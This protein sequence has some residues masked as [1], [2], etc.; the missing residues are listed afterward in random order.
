MGEV[1]SKGIEFRASASANI[2][3][4]T[5]LHVEES[6]TWLD[7][8]NITPGDSNYGKEL[9]YSS[10]TRSLFI[11]E[12]DR[13][14]WGSLTVLARYRGHEYSDPANTPSGKFQPV[15]TF[16]V[17]ISSRELTFEGIGLKILL[18]VV[19]LTNEH[20]E[21]IINYPI[22]GRTYHFSIELNYH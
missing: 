16:D 12:I 3:S 14:D 18:G 7:A 13:S 4:K 5:S 20:Y 9:Q 8:K 19:D 1:E 22:P 17:N 15:T 6:Y 11:A 21:D 10:P 2:D